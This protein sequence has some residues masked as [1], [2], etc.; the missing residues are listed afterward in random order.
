MGEGEETQL[1][2]IRGLTTYPN[3]CT[4]ARIMEGYIVVDFRLSADDVEWVVND[5][6]ELGV[7]I[8]DQFFFC[9]KGYSLVYGAL[10]EDPTLPPVHEDSDPSVGYALGDRMKWRPVNKREFGE[11]IHPINYADLTRIGT[12]DIN[13]GLDWLDIP[14]AFAPRGSQ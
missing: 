13:D 7:K 5:L 12:V 8:G 10:N 11:C 14:A 2:Q 3:T 9:Y 1:T 4:L 6:A